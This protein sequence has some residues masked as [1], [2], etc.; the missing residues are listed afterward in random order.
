MRLLRS[1]TLE[2]KDFQGSAIPQYA[3]LS[4]TWENEEVSFA[5]MH[6]RKHLSMEM[7]GFQKIKNCCLLAASVGYDWVWVDTC[8]IDKRSSAELSEAINAMFTWYER[9]QCCFAY[10]ADV[11]ARDDHPESGWEDLF[12]KSKW[13]TRGWTLQEL[14][15]PK[16]VIFYDQDWSEIGTKETLVGRISSI[17]GITDS[18]LLDS[19]NLQSA[20]V[21]QRMSWASRRQTTR[22]EDI[23]YCLMGLF[24]VNMPMLYGEGMKAFERLQLE[25]IKTL[26]D[27]SIFAWKATRPFSDLLA[28]SP[29]DFVDSGDIVAFN[30][31]RFMWPYTMTH[32]GVSIRL[33][34]LQSPNRP[35]IVF[36][37]C[38]Y[39]NKSTEKQWVAIF[40]EEDDE[41]DD[42]Y[43]RVKCDEIVLSDGPQDLRLNPR[44][45]VADHNYTLDDIKVF[46]PKNK[47]V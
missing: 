24:D 45:R 46:C 31:P 2:S 14:I 8:C 29:A 43:Y 18:I 41:F 15:A 37:N 44:W 22:E 20:S 32:L 19:S 23:A 12:R 40:L 47:K 38:G 34:F 39:K 16:T 42:V 5:D 25:I 33:P 7:A 11:P 1:T 13:F 28:T 3:I 17:T 26:Y 9:A 35:F 21:A 36:L 6:D 30:D 10:L 27:Q 4:H